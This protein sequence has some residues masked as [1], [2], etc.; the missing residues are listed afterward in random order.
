MKLG[1]REAADRDT[2][3]DLALRAL[4]TA[5]DED[6][7]T[8]GPDPVR[9]IWPIMATIT[10]EGFDRVCPTTSWPSATP[11]SARRSGRDRKAHLQHRRLPSRR[12][13][14]DR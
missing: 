3:V 12:R 8:G 9:G 11:A 6:S 2:T 5:A 1:Y 13:G 7:A 14:A 10:A 4:F